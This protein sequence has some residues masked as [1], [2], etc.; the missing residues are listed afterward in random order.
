MTN[1]TIPPSVTAKH[2]SFFDKLQNAKGAVVAI[3][4]D[5]FAKDGYAETA[6]MSRCQYVPEVLATL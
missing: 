5:P 6:Q 2:T 1:M 3:Y 4:P